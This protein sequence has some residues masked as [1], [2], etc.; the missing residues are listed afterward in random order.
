MVPAWHQGTSKDERVLYYAS[1]NRLTN[2]LTSVQMIP[3]LHFSVQMMMDDPNLKLG[4]VLQSVMD[5]LTTPGDACE[6]ASGNAETGEAKAKVPIPQHSM[7]MTL[8]SPTLLM[9]NSRRRRS[10]S[11]RNLAQPQ[12]SC[13]PRR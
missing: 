5:F 8:M 12:G 3:V 9:R 11:P 2:N 10:R 1:M 6:D 4:M 13:R 7:I